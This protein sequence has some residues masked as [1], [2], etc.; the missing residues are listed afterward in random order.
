MRTF[1][2]S[3][4]GGFLPA[5]LAAAAAYFILRLRREVALLRSRHEQDFRRLT[6]ALEQLQAA[7]LEL[8]EQHRASARPEVLP[9]SLVVHAG[10]NASQRAH[11]LRLAR[12]GDRPDQISAALGLP[13]H[14]INLTLKIH[15]A[16]LLS[17]KT[18]PLTSAARNAGR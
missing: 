12:R 7:Y 4:L 15:R 11:I 2:I 6:D 5:A 10:M 13:L 17:P 8:R 14:E 16:A 9:A 3:L 18:K 1:W